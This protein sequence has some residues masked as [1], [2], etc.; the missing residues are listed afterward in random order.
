MFERLGIIKYKADTISFDKMFEVAIEAGALDIIQEEANFIIETKP[1][2]L[3][4][5]A[6]NVIAQ[7][8]EEPNFLSIEYK[9]KM[10]VKIDNE[11]QAKSILKLIDALEDLDD[12]Q[13]VFANFDISEDLLERLG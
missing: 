8:K 11:D 12:V 3:H 10:E 5:V 2:D 4:L 13:K 6:S 9:P 7:I 1:E